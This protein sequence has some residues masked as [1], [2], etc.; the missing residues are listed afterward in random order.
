MTDFAF[1]ISKGSVAGR[2]RRVDANDPANSA[3]IL[4]PIDASTLQAVLEDLDDLAAVLADA[5]VTERN[6][7]GWARKTLTDAE[8]TAFVPDDVNNRVDLDFP[9]Q[10]WT[11]VLLAGGVVTGVLVCYDGDTGS[12]TDSDIE[13]LT[14]HDFPITPDGS[15]VTLETP[16]GFYRST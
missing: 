6:S 14:H 16:N 10:T 2:Y 1:N 3:L 8:L 15:D 7:N 5:G 4:V 13:P 11:A 9:D 12:G